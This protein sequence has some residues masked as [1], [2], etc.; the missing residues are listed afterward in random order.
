MQIKENCHLTK[1]VAFPF[2]FDDIF[3]SVSNY[4]CILHEENIYMSSSSLASPFLIDYFKL[5]SFVSGY[6]T[7]LHRRPKGFKQ[8]LEGI[9]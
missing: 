2:P 7:Q 9:S 6:K 5:S 4:L 8:C 1:Q 3:E